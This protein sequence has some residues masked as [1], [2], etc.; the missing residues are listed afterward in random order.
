MPGDLED[1]MHTWETSVPVVTV[2]IIRFVLI[3]IIVFSMRTWCMDFTKAFVLTRHLKKDFY[4]IH[5][6]KG[7]A[8]KDG[9]NCILW[10]KHTVHGE[11]VKPDALLYGPERLPHPMYFYPKQA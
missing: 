10:L 7:Y 5:L 1:E 8:T 2:S 9:S 4:Y 3:V 6:P 11:V